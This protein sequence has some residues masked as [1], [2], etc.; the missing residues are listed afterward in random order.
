VFVDNK[1]QQSSDGCEI[2]STLVESHN[3]KSPN[4][5]LSE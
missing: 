5:W 3:R 2:F 4:W 1:A